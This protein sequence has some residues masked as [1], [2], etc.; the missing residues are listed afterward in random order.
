M[1]TIAVKSLV[2]F[3]TKVEV[4]KVKVFHLVTTKFGILISTLKEIVT[5]I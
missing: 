3:L 1:T 5:T 2:V 4:A